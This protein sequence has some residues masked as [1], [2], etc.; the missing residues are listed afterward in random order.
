MS[1]V[2]K[3]P[4]AVEVL[5]AKFQLTVS[6]P[7]L[8]IIS[9][10]TVEKKRAS[11]AV[12]ARQKTGERSGPRLSVFARYLLSEWKRL[13]L[14]LT[15]QRFVIAVSGGA[16]STALLLALAELLKARR[17]SVSLIVA[18]LDHG[19]RE[20]AG[21]GDARWVA[22]LARELGVESVVESAD[23]RGR[24]AALR[25]NL[26]QAARRARYQFLAE[27]ASRVQSR[28][29][30]TAH[31][32][33]D[34]AETFL[35]R[36]M[37]GSGADGLGSI[38]PLRVLDERSGIENG[39]LLVRPMLRWAR[40]A[41]TEKYCRE[42]G[43][44]FRVDEMNTDERFARVRVRRELLPL[45]QTFNG[46]IVEALSRAAELLR[47]ESDALS[48]AAAELLERASEDAK[49]EGGEVKT[50]SSGTEASEPPT[51]RVDVLASAPRAVRLRALRQWIAAGRGDLRRLE[52]VHLEA[53]EHLLDGARGGRVAQ[54]P[55]G[56]MVERRRGT[57][58]LEIKRLKSE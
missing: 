23:V 36:L 18:H 48:R 29:V 53:V 14:P 10:D 2:L 4:H 39:A 6:R 13:E 5:F 58:R 26:E 8:T 41:E 55:G 7:G 19:L 35:L 3:R 25:D 34:Q 37:R 44:E 24:A 28:F 38:K 43:V 46:R 11:D 51:L 33:D 56:A 40:R 1:V 22:A 42:R 57:L 16:D 31:T 30:L 20:E 12:R 54:L 47:E 50:E 49:E 32:M 15:E 52:L 17:L 21:R 45:M 9:M 27:V